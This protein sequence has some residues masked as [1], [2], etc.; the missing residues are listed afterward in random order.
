MPYLLLVLAVSGLITYLIAHR[1][2]RS[3][4]DPAVTA[5]FYRSDP[6][7]SLAGA[8]PDFGFIDAFLGRWDRFAQGEN[9]L[10]P[11]I[12]R[13]TGRFNAE[14]VRALEAEPTQ[15]LS[16]TVLYPILQVGGFLP[17]DSP[18]G[19]A[20]TTAAAG[21]GIAPRL[22]RGRHY[23]FAG[24]LF[25]WWEQ[26]KASY[27]PLPLYEAWLTRDFTRE[28]AVPLYEGARA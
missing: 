26:H 25:H 28:V 5:A 4:L 15:A 20:F 6:P 14:L 16:R 7:T 17:L 22:V 1:R 12:Q 21:L 24:D 13:D 9:D 23:Y 3:P 18:L 11:D 2:R 8:V 27:P 19:Q 10:L